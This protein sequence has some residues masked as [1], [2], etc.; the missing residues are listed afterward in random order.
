MKTEVFRVHRHICRPFIPRPLHHKSL[1]TSYSA[2]PLPIL[3]PPAPPPSA[4]TFII[5]YWLNSR[6]Q[7]TAVDLRMRVQDVTKF[8]SPITFLKIKL[9][10][11]LA[12]GGERK[13]ERK[14][15]DRITNQ[16]RG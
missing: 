13:K 14:G 2:F 8:L 10:Q 1:P 4:H 16:G 9:Q 6:A 3:T 7:A 12:E 5:C 15:R 11:I